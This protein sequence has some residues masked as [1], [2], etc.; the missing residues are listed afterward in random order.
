MILNYTTATTSWK[1][2]LLFF[3]VLGC[4][5][6]GNGRIL[7]D[8]NGR[9]D[10]VRILP[11]TVS[12]AMKVSTTT[13]TSSVQIGTLTSIVQDWMSESFETNVLEK[14]LVSNTT[15]F[16]S[17]LLEQSDRRRRRTA[18]IEQQQRQ[19]QTITQLSDTVLVYSV[20]YDGITLWER[21][22][23][24][25]SPINP[26]IVEYLQRSALLEP[27]QLVL[28][29]D[30]RAAAES[31][32]L[33]QSVVDVQVSIATS[34][35]SNGDSDDNNKSLEIIIIVAIVV[36]CLAFG[37]LM[38]AVVWAWRTDK[39]KKETYKRSSH[40]RDI[41]RQVP[42]GDESEYNNNSNSRGEPYPKRQP[43]PHAVAVPIVKPRVA[44]VVSPA[45][46]SPSPVIL[47]DPENDNNTTYDFAD[48]VISEDISTS[49]TAYYRSGVAG[50]GGTKRSTAASTTSS[51]QQQH[52][53]PPQRD[54]NDAASMSSMDSYGY[55]LDGYAPSLG[56]APPGYPLG[57][58]PGTIKDT[59]PDYE[60]DDEEENH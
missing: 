57:P 16:D 45:E 6:V 46:S 14:G 2:T 20:T 53:A 19:L 36:A 3:C 28:L 56:P 49:L 37:L 43:S 10:L 22:D 33:G 60:N 39:T 4:A 13:T 41:K 34:T 9:T 29:S 24:S 44:Q 40:G 38:F 42:A 15:T 7:A 58:A 47:N 23:A 54:F 17:L 12:M 26:E 11:F 51:S 27:S 52:H 25:T 30:L 32:G 5:I 55:S 31:T 8:D 50:Y 35:D 21:A 1:Q 18:T 59:V 48:S